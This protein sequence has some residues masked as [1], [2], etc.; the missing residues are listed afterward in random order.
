MLIATRRRGMVRSMGR[1]HG[2]GTVATQV[3][4]SLVLSSDPV[5][6][7]YGNPANPMRPCPSWGC[8]GPPRLINMPVNPPQ[9][10][11]GPPTPGSGSTGSSLSVA[12]AL[13]QSNPSLLTADQWAQLQAAGLVASTLPY[14]SAGLVNTPNST[15]VPDPSAV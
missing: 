12:I 7:T 9:N 13:L 1:G 8:N 2:L 3:A 5:R 14:S 6:P 11:Y 10:W 4:G 15:V